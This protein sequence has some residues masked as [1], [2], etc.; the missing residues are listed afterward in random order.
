MEQFVECVPNFSV[1]ADEPLLDDIEQAMVATP[2]V[3][4]LDRTADLDHARS[5]FTLVGAPTAVRAALELSVALA[6][7][8]IDL[9]AH[10]GQHP[11]LGAVDVVPFVPLGSTTMATC[12]ELA[13][14]FAVRVSARH[15]IPVFLYAEAAQRVDRRVLADVRRPRF[16]GLAQAMA[17]PGGEPDYG[18]RHPH[19]SAGAIAVGA[20][21]LLIAYNIQLASDDLAVAT[22]IARRVRGRDGGLPGVQALGLALPSQGVI[23]VSMNVLDHELSPL[24]KVWEEV[25]S[26][27]SA[28]GIEVIDSELIGLAPR[29]AFDEVADHIGAPSGGPAEERH[30]AAMRWLRIRDHHPEMALE[31][32]LLAV[33]RQRP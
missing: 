2:D 14:E 32:R 15:D 27:A 23:Q 13:R 30:A 11:R 25:G 7:A 5:V 16:E 31:T 6:I 8:R 10:Q 28:G 20:R 26:L 3:W 17:R 18:P 33:R 24:W 9:R 29:A 21:P 1:A 22:R 12:I 4:L 19:P